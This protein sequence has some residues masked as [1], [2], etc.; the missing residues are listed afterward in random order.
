[1]RNIILI[2]ILLTLVSS[3]KFVK[4]EELP[5]ELDNDIFLQKGFEDRFHSSSIPRTNVK[6][7]IPKPIKQTKPMVNPG[8]S[9]KS[10]KYHNQDIPIH[11][12]VRKN[13]P[14]IPIRPTLAPLKVRFIGVPKQGLKV[15]PKNSQGIPNNI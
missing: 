9:N 7:I 13:R 5:K 6:H 15:K 12:P 4:R 11:M 2:M 3:K 8:I 10:K 14:T 1:M